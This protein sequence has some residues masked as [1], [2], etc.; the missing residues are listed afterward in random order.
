MSGESSCLILIER[1]RVRVG[2][3]VMDSGTSDQFGALPWPMTLHL[4]TQRVS[5]SKDGS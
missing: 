4:H 5:D 2:I 3:I 1:A